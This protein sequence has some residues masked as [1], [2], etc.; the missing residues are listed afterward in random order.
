MALG[1][2]RSITKKINNF[3]LHAMAKCPYKAQN[4]TLCHIA[5]M[6]SIDKSR[7]RTSVVDQLD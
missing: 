2:S 6:S 1:V 4:I 3:V 7:T 5:E